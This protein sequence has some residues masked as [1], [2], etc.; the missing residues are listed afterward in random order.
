MRRLVAL[1]VALMLVLASSAQATSTRRLA[2]RDRYETAAVVTLDRWDHPTDPVLASGE[3]PADALAGAFVSGLH[4]S[5]LLLTAADALPAATLDALRSIGPKV[6]H[7]LG[8]TASI[9]E[10]VVDQLQ[11]EG[12]VVKRHAGSDRYGTAVAAGLSEGP[13]II[14][15][16]RGEGRTAIMAN[17][18]RP[19]DALAAGPLSAGQLL[20]LVLTATDSVPAVTMQG[21]DD[22]RIDHVLVLGG[23][24]VVSDAVVH[25]LEE[26]GRTV[27]RIAGVD[28][29]G[30]AVAVADVLVD[31]LGYD[32]SVA[33][34]VSATEWADALAAGPW[35]Y[36]DKPV[37]LCETPS[38]CGA[39]T[40][41]WAKSHALD[42]IVVVGGEASVS[43]VAAMGVATPW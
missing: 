17:G 11:A 6:V 20:P 15:S 32:V 31:E 5:P 28:R 41:E 1:V 18:H 24:G 27:R 37:L 8:G 14:G 25:Q 43:D 38:F 7:V 12:W 3:D 16:Y 23:T 2:G 35:G 21:L 26:S 10:H 39:T 34:L 13:A 33:S 29:A 22:M 4:G 40:T 19:F 9:S 36:P 30:T 42:E